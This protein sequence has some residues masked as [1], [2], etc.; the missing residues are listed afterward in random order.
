MP[1]LDVR[2]SKPSL[3]EWIHLLRFD[4]GEWPLRRSILAFP[5]TAK[6]ICPR[7]ADFPSAPQ[8]RNIPPNRT[9][10]I[11]EFVHKYTGLS[12]FTIRDAHCNSLLYLFE[13]DDSE[14]T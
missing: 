1:K 13:F 2:Q 9:S 10:K 3:N 8:I 7:G 4:F 5:K 12:S 11:I 6:I 14:S